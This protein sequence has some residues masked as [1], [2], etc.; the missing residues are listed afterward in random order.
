MGR[1]SMTRSM[2]SYSLAVVLAA[3]VA[4]GNRL[5]P[6]SPQASPAAARDARVDWLDAHAVSLSTP[7]AGH[8]FADLEPLRAIVG[9]ARIVALGEGTHGTREFFQ[10]KH[11]LLEF[12]ASEMGYTLFSIEASTPEAYALDAYVQGGPGDPKALI[13]GMYFWT[14]NTEEVLALVEWMRAFNAAGKGP[15]HFTG[16][17]MQTPDLAME[18]VTGFL[19]GVD[20]ERA[21]EVEVAYARLKGAQ[22]SRSFGVAV[23]SFPVELVRG[24]R[25]RFSGWI[26]TEDLK[27]GWAGLW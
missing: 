14:W 23:G 24:K 16:F 2:V 12:L 21:Q 4:A 11:R 3:P 8:G 10:A 25:V 7:E 9:D 5:A 1:S 15:L 17:D 22:P 13:G 27:D 6:F 19:K 20:P 18:I 26:R